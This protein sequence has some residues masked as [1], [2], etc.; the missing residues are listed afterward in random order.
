MFTVSCPTVIFRN[1]QKVWT[2]NRVRVIREHET[3]GG[4]LY[5]RPI[6]SL[7]LSISYWCNLDDY[8]QCVTVH[9]CMCSF[10]LTLFPP[11]AWLAVTIARAIHCTDELI[12]I[13]SPVWSHIHTPR[14]SLSDHCLLVSW[15]F[16]VCPKFVETS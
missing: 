16:F 2:E 6:C 9:W 7:S 3:P 8:S 15:H 12:R 13:I 4:Y 11:L 5:L 1:Q 10:C 14:H